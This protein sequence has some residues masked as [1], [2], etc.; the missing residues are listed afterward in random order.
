[1]KAVCESAGP[2][3]FLAIGVPW[4]SPVHSIKD[5]KGKKIGISSP[6]SLTDWL[7]HELAR[8]EGW[9]PDGVETVAIG[10]STAA[11][12]A[13]FRA[14][15]VDA[16]IAGASL[17]FNFE[18]QKIG[19]LLAPVSTYEGNIAS[20]MLF[21]SD[22][23][24]ASDP[25]AIRAFL[26]GWIETIDYMRTHKAETVKIERGITHFDQTVMTKEYD[27]TIGMFTK[28]CRFDP[29][30]LANLKHSFVTLKLLDTE[31]DMTKLYTE[32]YLP[33]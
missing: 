27:L 28:A 7:A 9:G 33:K 19:R 18:E 4:N 24:I 29:E 10:G 3:P 14:H 8:K 20:G 25:A 12:E 23:L 26:A 30:S 16:E 31:P 2:A 21:A 15:Q 11:T 1:M 5:L 6:G 32:A 17:F 13:A 22:K